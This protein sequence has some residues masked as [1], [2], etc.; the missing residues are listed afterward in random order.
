MFLENGIPIL[1][2]SDCGHV[3]SSYEQDEHYSG[4]WQEEEFDLNW[5]DFAHREIYEEQQ[6]R[7]QEDVGNAKQQSPNDDAQ[8]RDAS[9]RIDGP[10][11]VRCVIV[12][13]P[14]LFI[15]RLAGTLVR[16]ARRR[17][18]LRVYQIVP[19]AALASRSSVAFKSNFL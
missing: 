1:K 14:A 2:C 4:Y 7:D 6:D 13:V 17:S 10:S 3:F 9:G 12:L 15:G 8:H 11:P 16:G 18:I 5:W 19:P